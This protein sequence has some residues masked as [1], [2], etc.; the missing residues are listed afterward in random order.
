MKAVILAAGRGSRLEGLTEEG[1]KP[2][3]RLLGLSLIERAILTAK[4]AGIKDFIIVTGHRA[5]Q[6]RQALSD[7]SSYG[8]SL[9]YVHNPDWP[10]GNG[11]SLAAVKGHIKGRFVLMMADHIFEPEILKNLKKQPLK[12]AIAIVVADPEPGE[13]IDMN[14][15]TKIKVDGSKVL[16]IG[17]SLDKYSHVDCGAFLMDERIFAYCDRL[18]ER[19]ILS[20][21]DIMDD[22]A[23]DGGL[24]ILETGGR[25]WIDVDTP[26]AYSKAEDL[27]CRALIKPTDGLVSRLL[28]RP[29]SLAISRKLVNTDISPNRIT[30]FSFFLSLVSA[31]F[32]SMGNY[33]ATLLGGLLVQLSSIIDGCDGEVARLKYRASEYGAWLDSVLDRYSDAFILLGATVGLYR[34]GLWGMELWILGYAALAGSLISSYTA[35]KYD[36]LIK[37]RGKAVWRFGRDTRLFIIM[38]GAIVNQL[39]YVLVFLAIFTNLVSLRRLYVMRP[40]HI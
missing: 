10:R 38:L 18:K 8:V 33:L 26:E 29:I 14:D 23:K 32:L 28:N 36:A 7:G 21:N 11:S 31:L 19:Q 15:A 12:D 17:K 1:P 35:T 20:L 9:S 5:E 27:L 2:L 3:V 25:F 34:Y 37:S 24:R 16:S 40:R 30:L 6:I 39:F 22:V 13:H 4:E